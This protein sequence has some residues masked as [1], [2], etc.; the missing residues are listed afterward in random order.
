MSSPSRPGQARRQETI[1][2]LCDAFARDEMELADFEKRVEAAHRAESAAELDRLLADIAPQNLPARAG[3]AAPGAA[4]VPARR[5]T[6]LPG[7]ARAREVVAGIMGG[8]TRRGRWTPARRVTAIGVMGGVEL[9]FREAV[10]APGV[11]EVHAFAFWGGVEIV[12]PPDVRVECTGM[13]IMGGFDHREDAVGTLDPNA[14]VLRVTGVACMGGVE[15]RVRYPGET[16]RDARR[17][18]RDER[19]HGRGRRLPP[20]SDDEEL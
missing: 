5:P 16:S 6:A 19:K 17:R 14:P 2:A 18:L 1:D 11:T 9:D 15:V 13:G 3:R 8:S 10:L 12:A 4:S 7:Q 20:G